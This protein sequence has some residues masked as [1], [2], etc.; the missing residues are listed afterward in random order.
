MSKSQVPN[1]EGP[2]NF[3]AFHLRL[4]IL[5]SLFPTPL[6]TGR[7]LT[8]SLLTRPPLSLIPGL[9]FQALL[10]LKTAPQYF[11]SF[12]RRLRQ[13]FPQRNQNEKPPASFE[14]FSLQ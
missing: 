7:L 4:P 10:W 9:T 3:A 5:P 14:L 13:T 12:S 8:R 1:R 11:F 2:P 6:Q